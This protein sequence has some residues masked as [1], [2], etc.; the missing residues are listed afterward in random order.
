LQDI[1]DTLLLKEVNMSDYPYVHEPE[2]A[3]FTEEGNFWIIL[4]STV[5]LAY[6]IHSIEGVDDEGNWIVRLV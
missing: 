6:R 4:F 3:F 2:I 1:L 5:Y